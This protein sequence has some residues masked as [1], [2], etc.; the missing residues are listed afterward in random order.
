MWNIVCKIMV[1]LAGGTFKK[2]WF[3]GFDCVFNKMS[4]RFHK[5]KLLVSKL[6]KASRLV[7]GGDFVLL[8]NTRNRLD[9]VDALP[10]RSLFLSGSSF[11]AIHSRLAKAKKSYCS[12]KSLESKCAKKSH[13]RQA[14]ERKIESFEVD[15]GHIIRSVLEHSFSKMVLD[16]LVDNGEL[17]LEPELVKSKPLDYVFDDVFS[18]VMHSISFNEMF[19]V[20]SNLPNGKAAGLSGITNELWKRCDKSVL[21]MLLVLLNFCLNCESR[22]LINTCPI[23][24]IKTAHKVLSKILSDQ[25]SLACSTFDVL[26]EDNFSVLKDMSTQSPIFTIGLVIEDALEKNQELWLVL[27]NMCKAYDSVGWEHLRR[28]LIRIKILMTDFDLTDRYYVHNGLNQGEIFLPLLW[29]IFYNLLLCKAGLTSFLAVSAF[30][31]DTIWVSNSQT[32]TQHILNVASNFFRLNNILINNDKTVVISINCQVTAPYLTIS[33]LP[34]SIAKR[35]EPHYYLRI[36]LSFKS[37]LKPSLVKVHSDVWFF[38]NLILKKVVLDKQ[39]AYLVSSVLFSIISYRTQFSYIPLSV[40]NKWDTLICKD[41]KSKSGLP[42]DFPNNALHHPSLYNLK[43]FEQ[44]QIESKS[45][46]VLSWHPCHPLLFPV[47]VRVSPSNNFLAG[48]ICIFS[49]CDLSLSGSLDSAFCLRSGI[50]MS[51]VLGEVVFYKCVSSLRRYDIA[52]MKQLCDQNGICWKRLD[53][54]GSVPF[55]FDFS[56]RFLGDIAS[57]SSASGCA[58]HEDVCG[59]SDICQSL[60]FGA[61]CNNLLNI[62][63]TCLFVYM[64]GSLSNLG[65]VD[66]LAG[67]AVFFEDINSGLG[68]RVSGLVSFTLAELQAIALALECVPAF[69]S[70]DLFSNSQ[71]ALDACKSEFLLV[72]LDFRNCECFLRAGGGV[73]S[74]NLRHFVET[75]SR[76]MVN[77]LR[78]NIN[79]LRSS[80]VW[81]PD[82][83]IAAGFISMQMAGFRMYFIKAFYHRLPVAVHKHLYNRYY[84]SVICLFC[85]NVKVSDHVFSCSSDAVC[86]VCLLDIYA[87]AWEMRSGLSFV[88]VYKDPEVAASNIVI[89]VHEFCLVFQDNVWLVHAKHQTVMEKNGLILHD[90]SIPISVSGITDALGIS[91]KFRSSCLFFSSISNMVSVLISA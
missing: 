82:S 91:F 23:A 3:K 87:A 29:C 26:C 40:C 83:Y 30:V 5:L 41:L 71:A 79:W 8:L 42:L 65:A 36:F 34:I 39:F 75:G 22:I 18:N 37:L 48:V 44:I 9:S 4:L 46:S 35:G 17:V 21:D 78:D 59:P 57:F 72:H 6:V 33:G 56:V 73:I 63:A 68:V 10:V 13:M 58:P 38:T 25:I 14:I 49:E 77:S 74:G 54:H 62:G 70:V 64:N 90:G 89:F 50:P 1:L 12:S 51:L 76:I 24:L 86:H 61:I 81:H 27:Q 43:T 15:K 85:G 80:L 66:M 16:H 32:A 67:A 20:V 11:N 52:F 31:D 84:S 19:D 69:H 53:P 47:H 45:A 60:G 7:S 28:S 55:W 88:S 2:K